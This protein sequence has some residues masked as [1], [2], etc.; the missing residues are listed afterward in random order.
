MKAR[1][2][3]QSDAEYREYLLHYYAGQALQGRCAFMPQSKEAYFDQLRLWRDDYG[4]VTL[5]TAIA[6]DAINIA[7]ALV[8]ELN[9]Q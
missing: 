9:K 5:G 4:E 6:K 2:E 1:N 8:E 7:N 3:F